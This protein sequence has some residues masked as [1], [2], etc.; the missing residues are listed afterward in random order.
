M[1]DVKGVSSFMVGKPYYNKV[2]RKPMSMKVGSL[3]LKSKKIK[4]LEDELKS[5]KAEDRAEV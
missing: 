2:R 1:D 3:F 5:L 4:E